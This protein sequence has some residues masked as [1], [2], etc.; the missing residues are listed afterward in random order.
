MLAVGEAKALP[1]F[2][3]LELRLTSPRSPSANIVISIVMVSYLMIVLDISIVI[4]AIPKIQAELGFSQPS[5][6]WVQNAFV[7]ALLVVLA[8]GMRSRK[9]VPA[10]PEVGLP[11][12]VE[13][14][15]K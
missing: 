11:S 4:T 8:V 1:T 6:S 2:V 9:R 15:A 12:A 7:L 5:L 10:L 13:A 14:V 3:R